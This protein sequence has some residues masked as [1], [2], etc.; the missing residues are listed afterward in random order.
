MRVL[1]GSRVFTPKGGMGRPALEANLN[2]KSILSPIRG[3]PR[4]SAPI[5]TLK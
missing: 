2:R 3:Y 4:L 1:T 5:R